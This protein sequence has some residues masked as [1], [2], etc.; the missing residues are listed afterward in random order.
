MSYQQGYND[1]HPECYDGE[2][3]YCN[4]SLEYFN[5][6]PFK[7]KRKGVTAY[8]RNG[9]VVSG[10]PVFVNIND[11]VDGLTPQEYFERQLNDSIAQYFGE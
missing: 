8:D 2:M 7:T 6:I 11:H 10:F 5:S 9:Q 4:S 3:W 1:K